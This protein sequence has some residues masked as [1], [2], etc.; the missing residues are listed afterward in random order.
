[1]KLFT[2][3]TNKLKS[4]SE[5]G[6]TLIELLV[7]IGILG[8]LAGSLVATIDPF[9]QLKKANDSKVQ[10]VGVEF[11]TANVRYYTG[12]NGF[13]WE[14]AGTCRTAAGSDDNVAPAL[15]LTALDDCV[16]DLIDA[17]EL[18]SGFLDVEGALDEV[19]IY[20]TANTLQVCYLPTSRSGQLDNST[21]YRGTPTAPAAPSTFAADAG[22]NCKTNGGAEDCYWCTQ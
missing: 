1:M 21:K 15:S 22:A 14:A 6:F 11:Q 12:Q 17:G 16:Q 13:P 9:E 20:E 4:A 19:F 2:V 18:K 7:V 8:I 3:Q 5:K 10:N